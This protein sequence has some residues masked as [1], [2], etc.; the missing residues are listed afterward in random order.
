MPLTGEINDLSLSE[1]IELFCNRRKTGRLTVE[2]PQ[3]TAQFYLKPGAIIHA[4]FEDLNGVEAV[5]Y[6]LTLPNASFSFQSGVKAPEHSI[7]QPWTSVVLD[8]LRKI[9]EGVVPIEP[10]SSGNSKAH[11]HHETAEAPPPIISEEPG[12][13]VN[14]FGVLL[15]R[16]PESAPPR[17][18]VNLPVL[19]A[20]VLIVLGI[21]VPWGWYTRNKA[22]Q[23]RREADDKKFEHLYAPTDPNPQPSPTQPPEA[24][25]PNPER[26]NPR[27]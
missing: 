3:G 13:D 9:D 22:S 20:I 27:K 17:R 19:V 5:H 25:Q 11:L 1:L 10:S 26:E 8:G 7:D 12:D 14:A 18:W 24:S 21:G 6:A 23:I 2:Y 4:A 15:S 16:Y